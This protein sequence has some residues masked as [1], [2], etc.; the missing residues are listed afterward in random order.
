L[1]NEGSKQK[2]FNQ[3]I[4]YRLDDNIKDRKLSRE[5]EI[6]LL[7]DFYQAIAD[8]SY[9]EYNIFYWDCTAPRKATPIARLNSSLLQDTKAFYEHY[10]ESLF[11]DPENFASLIETDCKFIESVMGRVFGSELKKLQMSFV[12]EELYAKYYKSLEKVNNNNEV[13]NEEND[14]SLK[15]AKIRGILKTFKPEDN[16]YTNTNHNEITQNNVSISQN[17]LK[18]LNTLLTYLKKEQETVGQYLESFEDSRHHQI[19][20]GFIVPDQNYDMLFDIGNNLTLR[21]IT[22]IGVEGRQ[23]KQKLESL[24]DRMV[25]L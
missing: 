7:K 10:K 16:T 9:N 20:R 24:D 3:R 25:F 6:K 11:Q 22:R 8:F 17:D 23:I 1:K 12:K 13:F 18:V 15:I 2:C 21:E 5:K 4:F 19:L 14:N